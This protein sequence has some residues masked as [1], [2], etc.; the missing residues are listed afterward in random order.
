[1]RERNIYQCTEECRNCTYEKKNPTGYDDDFDECTTDHCPQ[2]HY[3]LGNIDRINGRHSEGYGWNPL[4]EFCNQCK[5]TSCEDCIK[6]SNRDKKLRN[7]IPPE[8]KQPKKTTTKESEP[9]VVE[10]KEQEKTEANS[11]VEQALKIMEEEKKIAE[12]KIHDQAMLNTN[13]T[14]ID[15]D[16]IADATS[17]DDFDFDDFDEEK[18]K[19]I[20]TEKVIKEI[21]ETGINET[22]NDEK[23]IEESEETD[24]ID[25][26]MDITTN[27]E[28]EDYAD[29][30][31]D[32]DDIPAPDDY[33]EQD[34]ESQNNNNESK[35]DDSD[36]DNDDDDEE[37]LD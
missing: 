35:E 29:V 15:T 37:D 16:R 26:G 4:G 14:F 12:S 8:L 10:H 25:F 27:E 36:D 23:T 30:S 20:K 2:N 9:I 6:W 21:V 13:N 1:M 5:H 24:E 11:V 3:Q 33:E 7:N 28:T 34:E 17:M 31:F 32:E 19:E 22:P 18:L